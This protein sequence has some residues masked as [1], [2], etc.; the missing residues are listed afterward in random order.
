MS[1]L[2]GEIIRDL[3]TNHQGKLLGILV[4]L[5]FGLIIIKFGLIAGFFLI[6]CILIGYFIGKR[7]D[8]GDYVEFIE[9]IFRNRY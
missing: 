6:I 1:N 4:G 7:Y 2:L 5:I 8:E 9:R 3:I